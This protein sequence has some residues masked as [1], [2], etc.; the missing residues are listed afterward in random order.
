ML[1]YRSGIFPMADHRDDPEVYWVEP[2]ERAV[3][4]L[5]GFRLSSPSART[6]LTNSPGE[7]LRALSAMT[8]RFLAF[9]QAMRA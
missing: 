1:A 8:A 4:P 2:C 7:V 6:W 3:I 9:R 5:D